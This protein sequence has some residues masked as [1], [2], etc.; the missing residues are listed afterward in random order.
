MTAAQAQAQALAAA[1]EVQSLQVVKA[2]VK[3]AVHQLCAL[4][5]LFPDKAFNNRS[6]AGLD[7]MHELKA[8]VCSLRTRALQSVLLNWVCRP[9]LPSF[10]GL[11]ALLPS[12]CAQRDYSCE[13]A[14]VMRWIEEGACVLE[15]ATQQHCPP[16]GVAKLPRIRASHAA[17]VCAARR[18]RICASVLTQ[19]RVED[20]A[21]VRH[22]ALGFGHCVR[23]S[24]CAL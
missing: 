17:R 9:P 8:R 22:G 20:L 16:I 10:S 21:A 6:M 13:T 18:G 5:A 11:T 1:T 19:R 2:L 4:R 24:N 12:C 7:N 3:L 14:T 15:T 23:E